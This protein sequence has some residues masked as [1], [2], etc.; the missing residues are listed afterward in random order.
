M[1]FKES[2]FVREGGAVSQFSAGRYN[3]SVWERA[4]AMSCGVLQRRWVVGSFG[5][6]QH[7]QGL[8]QGDG[9]E[10]AHFHCFRGGVVHV[11]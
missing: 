5:G 11:S 3:V 6:T 4:A 2:V 8:R 7:S 10:R 1:G 9:E